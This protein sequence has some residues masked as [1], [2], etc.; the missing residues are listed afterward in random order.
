MM[1]QIKRLFT[2]VA[3]IIIIMHLHFFKKVMHSNLVLEYITL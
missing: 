2:F 1:K 3:L